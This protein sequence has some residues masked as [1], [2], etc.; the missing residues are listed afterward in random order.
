V[1]TVL[2]SIKITL[3]MELILVEE[4]EK[5]VKRNKSK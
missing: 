1:L 3:L 2:H 4:A 5:G